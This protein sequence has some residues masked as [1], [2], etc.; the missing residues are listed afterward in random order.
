MLKYAFLFLF[1]SA[2]TDGRVIVRNIAEG[3]VEEKI[4]ISEHI[5][6][7]IQF[8]G[9]WMSQHPCLCWHSHVKVGYNYVLCIPF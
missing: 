7:A 1:C 2:S 4:L 8:D 5:V 6:V 3:R 9:D